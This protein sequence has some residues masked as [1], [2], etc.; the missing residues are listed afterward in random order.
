MLKLTISVSC[1]PTVV[2]PIASIND[3]RNNS[4]ACRNRSDEAV[5]T[6]VSRDRPEPKTINRLTVLRIE[7]A[8]GRSDNTA[9][10]NLQLP[11]D[12]A[13][14]LRSTSAARCIFATSN[15]HQCALD[16]P[17]FTLSCGAETTQV[18]RLDT[19]ALKLHKRL[20]HRKRIFAKNIGC[21][22]QRRRNRIAQE[23]GAC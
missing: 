12:F 16:E 3:I 11:S 6:S 5:P 4:A 2:T 8:E 20:E 15:R 18:P 19:T 21:H 13:S 14:H 22:N 17:E 23:H 10:N 1:Y 7:P 9:A